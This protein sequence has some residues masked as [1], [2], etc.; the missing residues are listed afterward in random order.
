[1]KVVIIK[2]KS[3]E[4]LEKEINEMI[5]LLEKEYTIIDVQYVS[6]VFGPYEEGNDKFL[7]SA[8]IKYRRGHSLG[9]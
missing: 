3:P 5:V 4:R 1:M 9:D 8:M 7:F 6:P 2:A